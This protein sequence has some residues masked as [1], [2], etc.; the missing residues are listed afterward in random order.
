MKAAIRMKIILQYT[1]KL[2]ANSDIANSDKLTHL[3]TT[4]K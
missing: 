4:V 1:K 3:L 2:L